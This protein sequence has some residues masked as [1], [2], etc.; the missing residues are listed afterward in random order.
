M[1]GKT[2][3]EIEIILQ[4]EGRSQSLAYQNQMK[5]KSFYRL[6]KDSIAFSAKDGYIIHLE[7]HKKTW[8]F[9]VK[10]FQIEISNNW[11]R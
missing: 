5:Q 2:T 3:D 11:W 7:Y 4:F 8:K 6:G 10:F 9:P 1:N